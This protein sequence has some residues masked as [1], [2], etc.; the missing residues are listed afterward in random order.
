MAKFQRK[1]EQNS[2]SLENDSDLD[3][4]IPPAA[5]PTLTTLSGG[6]PSA[7]DI[8]LSALSESPHVGASDDEDTDELEL[9][10]MGVGLSVKDENFIVQFFRGVVEEYKIVEWPSME[11]VLKITIIIIVSLIVA[12]VAIYLIDGFFFRIFQALLESDE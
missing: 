11:R 4:I 6:G 3:K 5:L 2:Q 9:S 7:T 12:I 10:S 1:E 8:D